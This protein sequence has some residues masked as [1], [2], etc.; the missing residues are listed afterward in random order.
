MDK[1]FLYDQD[2]YGWTQQ[3][4]KA[5][6][7]RLVMELDWQHLQ[8]EALLD[9]FE[10]GIDLALRETNL[11]LRAFPEHCPYLFD[12][13]MSTTGYAYADNFLCDTRQDWEG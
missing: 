11:P 7:Q 10:A 12:N 3:Q 9:G 2:F 4:A 13:A 5:L 6:E 8:E 1:P